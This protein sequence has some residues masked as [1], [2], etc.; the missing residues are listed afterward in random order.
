[1]KKIR[2]LSIF[3]LAICLSLV[4]TG[5]KETSKYDIKE[6]KSAKNVVINKKETKISFDVDNI[7]SEFNPS[8]IVISKAKAVVYTDK[9]CSKEAEVPLKLEEGNNKFYFRVILDKGNKLLKKTVW[10]LNINRLE[11]VEGVEYKLYSFEKL[12]NVGDS[13]KGGRIKKTVNGNETYIEITESMVTGFSTSKEGKYQV[14]IKYE[15]QTF[16]VEITVFPKGQLLIPNYPEITPSELNV[17]DIYRDLAIMIVKINNG[18]VSDDK[19]EELIK[20]VLEDKDSENYCFVLSRAFKE[21]GLTKVQVEQ[22][23]NHILKCFEGY[24][25]ENS[26]FI[27]A[28]VDMISRIISVFYDVDTIISEEQIG[29]IIFTAYKKNQQWYLRLQPIIESLKENPKYE[30]MIKTIQDTDQ[31]LTSRNEIMYIGIAGY[32]E[33][34]EIS[35]VIKNDMD[36]ITGVIEIVNGYMENGTLEINEEFI[37]NLNNVGEIIDGLFQKIGK[38]TLNTCLTIVSTMLGK[39]FDDVEEYFEKL[40]IIEII[41]NID[42]IVK[43]ITNYLKNIKLDDKDD[44]EETLNAIMLITNLGNSSLTNEAKIDLGHSLVVVSKIL[45]TEI[46]KLSTA[47]KLQLNN[48]LNILCEKDGN[49]ISST[50]VFALITKLANVDLSKATDEN[51]VS[52]VDELQGIMKPTQ[53]LGYNLEDE[54]IVKQNTTKEE[55]VEQFKDIIKLYKY[56]LNTNGE[57]DSQDVELA[58]NLLTTFDTSTVGAKLLKVTIDNMTISIAYFVEGVEHDYVMSPGELNLITDLFVYDLNNNVYPNK[59]FHYIVTIVD[60]VT[61]YAY[62]VELDTAKLKIENPDISTVGKKMGILTIDLDEYG[63]YYLPTEYYVIDLEN[64]V[65]SNYRVDFNNE[66]FV[67]KEIMAAG[68][69]MV[70]YNYRINVETSEE[71]GKLVWQYNN[72]QYLSFD[73]T[74]ITGLDKNKEGTQKVTIT[75]NG[76]NFETEIYVHPLSDAKKIKSAAFSMTYNYAENKD[77]KDQLYI[78]IICVDDEYTIQSLTYEKALE[79]IKENELPFEITFEP[80][81]EVKLGSNPFKLTVRDTLHDETFTFEDNVNIIE[82]EKF[83]ALSNIH[84]T[85]S[86]YNLLLTDETDDDILRLITQI[87]FDGS[88]YSGYVVDDEAYKW[89]KENIEV[90]RNVAE[91]TIIFRAHGAEYTA[92]NVFFGLSIY[93]STLEFYNNDSALPEFVNDFSDEDLF[94]G[95]VANIRFNNNLIVNSS[96]LNMYQKYHNYID[97]VREKDQIVFSI[98]GEQVKTFTILKSSDY[99]V[100]FNYTLTSDARLNIDDL[101]GT[102]INQ[103]IRVNFRAETSSTIINLYLENKAIT[104]SILN[105]ITFENVPT[106]VG[107]HPL[108]IS[109]KGA[110]ATMTATWY[111]NATAKNVL[112]FELFITGVLYKDTKKLDDLINY[113]HSLTVDYNDGTFKNLTKDE[114]RDFLT[115]ECT[116]TI[117]DDEVKIVHN[118]SGIEKVYS[119]T[120]DIKWYEIST[121]TVSDNTSIS[122]AHTTENGVSKYQYTVYFYFF[123]TNQTDANFV[124]TGDAGKYMA[125]EFFKLEYEENTGKKVFTYIVNGK[126]I[127]D[128]IIEW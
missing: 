22:L 19:L 15:G 113:I 17:D 107:E 32:Q 74:N 6:V 102:I 82:K 83:L 81:G 31:V 62:S 18:E 2:V 29:Q 90:V 76:Y 118:A 117:T 95:I 112:G 116:V 105:Y 36:T 40:N 53:K 64:P 61:G 103:L 121:I 88:Y 52:Y 23:I 60:M 123:T 67:G 79:K 56:T 55:F 92:Y 42:P 30:A 66:L 106:E 125:V 98:G 20:E 12:Y 104:D 119:N 26:N 11:K 50:A 38:N 49:N 126:T 71:P 85:L 35:K 84:V 75:I 97:I 127:K 46:S 70:E 94:N 115:K 8:N 63:I 47:E 13:F 108:Q 37:T 120:S 33:L 7:V 25:S 3:L 43:I 78:Y 68:Q 59:W 86:E 73:E 14:T 16:N 124:A 24:D 99:T 69:I 111:S 10:E 57:Y 21:A 4:F 89:A 110:S 93:N 100:Y 91:N 58:V 114:C 109:F 41:K 54:I 44:I 45:S 122:I 128:T 27:D 87:N 39:E 65:V 48:L 80:L 34:K 28:I 77:I 1:M 9:D 96:S 101:N 72:S 51:L 5:C